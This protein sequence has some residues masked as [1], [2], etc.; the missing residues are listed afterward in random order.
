MTVKIVVEQFN[1][2]NN[3]NLDYYD[4]NFPFKANNDVPKFQVR[5]YVNNTC[6]P[7]NID[8]D[9][10]FSRKYRR[11]FNELKSLFCKEYGGLYDSPNREYNP[12]ELMNSTIKVLKDKI[13]KTFIVP[14]EIELSSIELLGNWEVYSGSENSTLNEELEIQMMNELQRKLKG[15]F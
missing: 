1:I 4:P 10:Q 6:F 14:G 12:L 11:Q 9:I 15:D 3:S 2:F 13:E 7:E 8:G 5:F